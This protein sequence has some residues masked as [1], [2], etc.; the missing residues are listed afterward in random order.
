[1]LLAERPPPDSLQAGNWYTMVSSGPAYGGLTGPDEVLHPRFP[2]GPLTGEFDPCVAGGNP[3]FG[4]GRPENPCDRYHF[5]S[6]HV[7]GANFASCDG[8]TGSLRRAAREQLIPLA[9]P[10]GGEVVALSE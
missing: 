7:G 1:M 2:V 4:P 10:A 8:S 9:T 3:D 6:W 5:W